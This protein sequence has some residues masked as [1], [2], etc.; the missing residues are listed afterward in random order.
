[1]KTRSTIT[2]GML[3]AVIVSVSGALADAIK[4]TSGEIVSGQIASFR[5]NATTPA[6]SV[7]VIEVDGRPK[8]IPLSDV[9]QILFD[10]VGP[11]RGAGKANAD[12]AGAKQTEDSSADAK[13][14]YW[15]S[16]TGKRHNSSCRHYKSSKGR[17]CGK[18]DG[19]PCKLCGG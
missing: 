4:T 14:E 11:G 13:G 6:E 17:P 2:A 5:R 19:S 9:D 15:L 1:M 7:F 16:S 8:T 10:R 3:L 18:D 12:A